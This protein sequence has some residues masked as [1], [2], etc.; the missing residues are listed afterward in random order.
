ML[1]ILQNTVTENKLSKVPVQDI[2]LIKI[3]L[4]N[5]NVLQNKCILTLSEWFQ[6]WWEK[7]E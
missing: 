2:E 3:R 4:S 1:S 6:S 5:M 7:K